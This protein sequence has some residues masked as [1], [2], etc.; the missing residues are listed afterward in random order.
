MKQ[1][2]LFQEIIRTVQNNVSSSLAK[3]VNKII[4]EIKH[5]HTNKGV[6]NVSTNSNSG[7]TTQ[8][9][10]PTEEGESIAQY[11]YNLFALHYCRMYVDIQNHIK[12]LSGKNEST[13]SLTVVYPGTKNKQCSQNTLR[14]T[15]QH[16]TSQTENSMSISWELLVK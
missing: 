7:Y 11:T 1:A 8:H 12:F 3:P 2:E 14:P 13:T 15:Q 5:L 10:L 16:K 6:M 4:S 9:C